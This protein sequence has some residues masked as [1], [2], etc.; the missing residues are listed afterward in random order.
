[1]SM[2][3]PLTPPGPPGMVGPLAQGPVGVGQ[4][5]EQGGV[6]QPS[7]EGALVFAPPLARRHKPVTP[8]A[9]LWQ[10]SGLL[11]KVGLPA[12]RLVDQGVKQE[13][14][15]VTQPS[16]EGARVSALQTD[17]SHMPVTPRTALLMLLGLPGRA[18]LHVAKPV[19]EGSRADP[20]HAE[21]PSTEEAR[22]P[23]L[24]QGA[25]HGAAIPTTVLSTPSTPRRRSTSW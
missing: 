7:L 21:W 6:T 12:R 20:K 16:V 1:M 25:S 8:T 14:G 2:F 15:L 13:H 24:L 18:G 11:G 17:R 23:A 5:P 9:A 22:Q 4:G 10:L 19:G 3:A